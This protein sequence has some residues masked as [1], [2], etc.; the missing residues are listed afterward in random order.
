MKVRTDK[1]IIDDKIIDIVIKVFLDVT[2]NNNLWFWNFIEL[3][4]V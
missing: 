1:K 4:W 3:F 2:E